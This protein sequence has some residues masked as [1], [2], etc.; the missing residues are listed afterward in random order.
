MLNQD[1]FEGEE[2]FQ[3]ALKLHED[4]LEGKDLLKLPHNRDFRMKLKELYQIKADS[5]VVQEPDLDTKR[6]GYLVNQ[7]DIICNQVELVK[8]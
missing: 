4:D 7:V 1:N 6:L 2:D 8:A 3:E 5:D